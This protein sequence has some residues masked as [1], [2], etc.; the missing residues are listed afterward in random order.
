MN[1]SKFDEQKGREQDR[2]MDIEERQACESWRNYEIDTRI[3]RSDNTV[4]E[5]D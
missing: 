4:N 1:L 2:Q 3:R 5:G